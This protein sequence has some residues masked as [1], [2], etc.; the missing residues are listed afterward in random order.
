MVQ[1]SV[2]AAAADGERSSDA[3]MCVQRRELNSFN[4]CKCTQGFSGKRELRRALTWFSAC[5]RT[6]QRGAERAPGAVRAL[7]LQIRPYEQRALY[8]PIP[9]SNP[10]T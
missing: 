2:A 8:F 1:R 3:P 9:I 5:E 6:R 10:L 7:R 4:H